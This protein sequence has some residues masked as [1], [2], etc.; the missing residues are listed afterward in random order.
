ML[1]STAS[2]IV[3]GSPDA[4]LVLGADGRYLDAN[5]AACHLLRYSRDELLQLQSRD[6]IPQD[7]S[8]LAEAQDSY[9][10]EGNW[11]GEIALVR[12]DGTLVPVEA[13]SVLIPGPDGPLSVA[14][15]RDLADQK[16][17]EAANARL[18][19]LVQASP[20]AIISL[21]LEGHII[22]WNPA[23][24]HL[25]GYT[26]EEALGQPMTML[27]P[28]ERVPE[29]NDVLA[30]VRSGESIVGLETVRRTKDGRLIEV[31][32]TVAPVRDAAGAVVASAGIIR[33]ITE[34]KQQ[35]ATLRQS[36][37]RFRSAFE[38]TPIGMT[39]VGLD[40]R[41]LQVNAAMCALTGYTEAELLARAFQDI[42]HPDD[43]APELAQAERLLTGEIRVFRLEK[44][45]VR[46]DGEVVW[47]CVNSSLVRDEHGTPLHVI[48]QVED[49]TARKQAE[50]DLKAVET[51]NRTLVEQLPVVVTLNAPDAT[52][53][54][55]Y[56]S[57]ASEAL[58]G[59]TPDEYLADPTLWIETVHLDD[60]ERVLAEVAGMNATGEAYQ[61]EYRMLTRDGR[62]VW[63]LE[64]STLVRDGDGRP[65]YWQTVQM[66]VTDRKQAEQALGQSEARF[67]T[68]FEHAPIGMDLVTLEGHF[69]QVNA[70]LCALLGYT[71]AELLATTFH[72]ITHPD[73]RATDLEQAEQLLS[74]EIPSFLVEKRYLRKDGTTVWVCLNAS[75]VRDEHGAPL[76]FIGQIEDIT[77]RKQAEEELRSAMEAT[78]AANRAKGVFLDL[79]SHELRTP[80]QAVLGYSEFLLLAPQDSLTDAQ[81]EDIGY[82]HQAGGRMLALINQV[83]DLS[84][85][86]AGG[87]DL[88][89]K[90]FDLTRIIEAVRQDIAPQARAKGLTVEI[91]L[92]P[93]LPRI[94]GDAERVR[95]I[96]LNLAGNA[97]KFTQQG[98]I[99]ITASSAE[100]GGVEVAVSDTGIGIPADALPHIFEAF[101]QVESGHTRHH[102]GSGLGLS[103]AW[104]L[105]QQMGGS[106]R[107]SSEPGVG[108]TFTLHLPCGA[109]HA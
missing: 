14:F 6:V 80:L 79:M 78:Q 93:S 90:P 18:A 83:L 28:P 24:E 4:V 86:E 23:A 87:I 91:T 68:A 89:A 96:L 53:S 58:F 65:L 84:R 29:S 13:W 109:Y 43:L 12:K 51:R 99:R 19:A 52:L 41:Y 106:L 71:E 15:L 75:L 77:G 100:S 73:D 69:L 54:T 76:H 38:H 42:T 1:P 108:S 70:A 46:K 17:D 3:A 16:R 74:G 63:I 45:Y 8:W 97:V 92:P 94:T 26:A 59:Y 57:P 107:V 27:V 10:A 39:L 35:E 88:A 101:H 32:L 72:D 5:P 34:R 50:A 67:R 36:E 49:I 21:S 66:D 61:D 48:G 98:H 85:L 102:Q 33:D 37:E 81:R 95:Q 56:V 62:V 64:D 31:A 82:I 30:R 2:V 104:K 60:R 55:L 7:A 9:Y 20:D 11:R 105:A 47:G 44:R 25:Y 22:D 103:I 40:G